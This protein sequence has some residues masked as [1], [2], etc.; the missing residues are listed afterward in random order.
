MTAEVFFCCY[1]HMNT[2]EKKN[3]NKMYEHNYLTPIQRKKLQD[4]NV[5]GHT[6]SSWHP[7]LFLILKRWSLP[8]PFPSALLPASFT[9]THQAPASNF[10][11]LFSY[12]PHSLQRLLHLL[13]LPKVLLD[14]RSS[15]P[16]TWCDLSLTLSMS[17]GPYNRAFP[18]HL[19]PA[20]CLRLSH[21]PPVHPDFAIQLHAL[22]LPCPQTDWI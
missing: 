14:N 8:S 20:S 2:G 3:Q 5:L 12:H 15:F 6:L 22:P 10:L 4:P 13:H 19:L 11:Q 16:L 7:G 17:P 18:E 1:T 21:C 9:T